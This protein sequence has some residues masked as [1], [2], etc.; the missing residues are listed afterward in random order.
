MCRMILLKNKFNQVLA[1]FF[2]FSK[3]KLLLFFVSIKFTLIFT[4]LFAFL[5]NEIFAHA[6]RSRAFVCFFFQNKMISTD[7]WKKKEAHTSST[8]FRYLC[9]NVFFIRVANLNLRFNSNDSIPIHLRVIFISVAV[10]YPCQP[11]KRE[12]KKP[13]YDEPNKNIGIIHARRNLNSMCVF[14][15]LFES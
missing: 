1:L 9:F 6:I 13:K 4:H 11:E 15:S 3:L 12:E 7:Q 8:I 5:V 10:D 2:V 14:F